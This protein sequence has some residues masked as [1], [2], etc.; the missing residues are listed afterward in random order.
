[1]NNEILKQILNELDY[2]EK[3]YPDQHLSK[4]QA[5]KK[6][7]VKLNNTYDYSNDPCCCCPDCT[8]SKKFTCNAFA[9]IAILIRGIEEAMKENEKGFF[10]WK[11]KS[12]FQEMVW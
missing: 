9:A 8:D 11:P 4:G 12:L 10:F 3:K 2:A 7:T 1:M 6:A 5:L